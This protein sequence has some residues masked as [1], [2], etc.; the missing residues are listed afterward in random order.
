MKKRSSNIAFH[1]AAAA[2]TFVLFC[3]VLGHAL[4]AWAIAPEQPQLVMPAAEPFVVVGEAVAPLA[5]GQVALPSGEATPLLHVLVFCAA[6]GLALLA[7]GV[8]FYLGRLAPVA[9]LDLSAPHREPLR[10][11][12]APVELRDCCQVEV[13]EAA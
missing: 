3:G 13:R 4:Q 12:P 2:V 5:A 9:S 6:L 1:V 10:P 7:F 8:L 11:A